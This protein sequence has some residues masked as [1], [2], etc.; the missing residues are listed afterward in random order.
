M[1]DNFSS[2]I[3]YHHDL[4]VSQLDQTIGEDIN[5]FE[6]VVYSLMNSYLSVVSSDAL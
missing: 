1:F 4:I 6:P 3:G 5:L 2:K